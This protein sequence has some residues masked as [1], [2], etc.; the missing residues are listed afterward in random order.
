ME[1]IALTALA[2]E[3]LDIARTASN[4]RSSHTV[5]GGHDHRLRQTLLALAAG[6]ELAEHESPGEATLQVLA[7][8]VRLS[9]SSD[10][11]ELSAGD[12]TMIPDER[13][14]LLAIDDCAVLLTVSLQN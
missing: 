5:L 6:Q 11:I 7:G 10:S 3:H 1:A 9:A 12:W 14:A 13:H 8:V 4:R 2:N